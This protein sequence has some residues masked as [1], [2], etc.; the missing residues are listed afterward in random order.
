MNSLVLLTVNSDILR[1]DKI[2]AKY[3]ANWYDA[4][5]EIIGRIGTSSTALS[6][7]NLSILAVPKNRAGAETVDYNLF[8]SYSENSDL[9]FVKTVVSFSLWLQ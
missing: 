6:F 3:F 2:L 5:L 7:F 4:V 9:I 1:R 8:Y